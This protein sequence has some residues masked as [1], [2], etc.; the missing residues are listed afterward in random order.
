MT[1]GPLVPKRTIDGG[2]PSDLPQ[3]PLTYPGKPLAHRF[4]PLDQPRKFEAPKHESQNMVATDTSFNPVATIDYPDKFIQVG[5]ISNMD[6]R[7]LTPVAMYGRVLL[8]AGG[9]GIFEVSE[10]LRRPLEARID[11]LS[12]AHKTTSDQTEATQAPSTPVAVNLPKTSTKIITQNVEQVQTELENLKELARQELTKRQQIPVVT[13]IPTTTNITEPAQT[14]VASQPPPLARTATVSNIQTPVQTAPPVEPVNKG[15]STPEEETFKLLAA[16]DKLEDE[17]TKLREEIDVPPKL[18]GPSIDVKTAEPLSVEIPVP[19]PL[20]QVTPEVQKLTE[21]KTDLERRLADLQ[22]LYAA[23]IE[24][25]QADT[26]I[27]QIEKLQTEKSDLGKKFEDLNNSFNDEVR[28][29]QQL[30]IKMEGLTREVQRQ[31]QEANLEKQALQGQIRQLEQKTAEMNQ[32]QALNEELNRQIENMKDKLN[33]A[34]QERDDAVLRERKAQTLLDALRNK[35]IQ[36]E[37]PIK[38][39]VE[40]SYQEP[41]QEETP[42]VKIVPPQMA[43]G[44]MA[45]TLTNTP[46]VINGVVKDPNGHLLTNVIIVVKDSDNQPVRALKSNKIGQFAISTPLPNGTYTMELEAEGHTFDIIQVKVDGKLL[47]P[48]EIKATN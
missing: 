22:N 34:T 21:E 5:R 38:K 13:T 19:T 18:S 1:Q 41:A 32:K 6:A 45:P 11:R 29:S 10:D 46:N 14:P 28:Q 26:H 15:V 44:K 2:L 40:P 9:A 17:L 30:E 48:I 20:A 43:V 31:I 25:Q 42:A 35:S 16:A 47:P 39:V 12:S 24:K 23:A 3:Q 4:N 37:E 8:P 36:S 7:S 27:L 33:T